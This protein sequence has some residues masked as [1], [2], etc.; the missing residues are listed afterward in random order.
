MCRCTPE[1]KSPFCGA[2]GCEWPPQ[3]APLKPITQ[4]GRELL[5]VA[6]PHERRLA[7][8]LAMKLDSAFLQS[9]QGV[10]GALR[11]YYEA[12]REARDFLERS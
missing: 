5:R 9:K 11:T 6:E 2:P 10:Q 7:L 4:L 3:A 12:T 1:I 8:A